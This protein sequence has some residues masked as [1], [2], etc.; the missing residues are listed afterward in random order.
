VRHGLDFVDL[1][2]SKVRRPTVRLGQRIMI[3]AELSRC[4]PTLDGGVEHAADIGARDGSPVHAD[5]AE[6]PA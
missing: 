3:G 6:A 4:A 2:N 5:A 1:Q